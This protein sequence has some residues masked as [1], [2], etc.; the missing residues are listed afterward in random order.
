MN[1]K[2]EAVTTGGCT[3]RE[4]MYVSLSLNNTYNGLGQPDKAYEFKKLN[5]K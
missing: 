5:L 1:L 3:P 4:V 2:L